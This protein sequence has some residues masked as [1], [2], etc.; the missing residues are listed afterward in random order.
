[1]LLSATMLISSCEKTEIQEP[2]IELN[3]DCCDDNG[4]I[5]EKPKKDD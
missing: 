4:T 1:M 2:S 3:K 5:P